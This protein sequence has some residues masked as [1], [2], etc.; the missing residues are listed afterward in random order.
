MC[1]DLYLDRET[2]Q[3][4]RVG[5]LDI[6]LWEGRD[7]GCCVG[8]HRSGSVYLQSLWGFSGSGLGL[9]G[10]V[11][12]RVKRSGGVTRELGLGVNPEPLT[13]IKYQGR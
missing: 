11:R 5:R 10:G 7:R 4:K 3:I 6:V 13:L 8:Q 1:V 9:R 2:T 12:V